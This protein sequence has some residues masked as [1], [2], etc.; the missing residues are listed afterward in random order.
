MDLAHLYNVA[1]I[2]NI[3]IT[4]QDVLDQ[5]SNINVN[6]L[7]GPDVV[8]PLKQLSS[9][10]CKPLVKLFNKSLELKYLPYIWKQANVTPVLK[11]KG[12]ADTVDN[13]RPI[14]L[15]SAICKC[16]EKIM[17]KIHL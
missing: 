1:T 10:I 13:Y 3:L 5:L 9:S 11:G 2:E 7:P 17:F 12:S 4:E 16:M 15:T 8:T 14:S 6:K